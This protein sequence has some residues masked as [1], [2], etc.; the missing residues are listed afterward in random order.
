M[1][2]RK[3]FHGSALHF[4]YSKDCHYSLP[5][6]CVRSMWRLKS[7]NVIDVSLLQRW[8]RLRS[9][10]ER[11]FP[12]QL[13]LFGERSVV[14]RRNCDLRTRFSSLSQNL[15]W[16]RPNFAFLHMSLLLYTVKDMIGIHQQETSEEDTVIT[17]A[18]KVTYK[19][20]DIFR[21]FRWPRCK[22]RRQMSDHCSK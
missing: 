18:M 9:N 3:C 16:Q 11:G 4:C 1:C 14:S 13:T 17:F 7:H 10:R 20:V 15:N 12:S 22:R 2:S 5:L 8:A 19:W 21:Q 6:S